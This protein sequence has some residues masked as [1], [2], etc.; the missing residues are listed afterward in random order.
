MDK[1]KKAALKAERKEF[2]RQMSILFKENMNITDRYIESIK[3]ED[4]RAHIKVNLRNVDSPFSIYSNGCILDQ[5]IFDYIDGRTEH[6]RS[7]MPLSIDFLVKKDFSQKTEDD[8][9][10]SYKAHYHIAYEEKRRSIKTNRMISIILMVIGILVL[11]LYATVEILNVI[12]KGEGIILSELISIVA[13][14]FIWEATD[15]IFFE[16]TLKKIDTFA[17][18]QLAIAEINIVREK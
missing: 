16:S 13:W 12:F 17:A 4:Q 1:N 6:I 18:G 15:K 11:M 2:Q 10:I 5:S 9:R 7:S 14:V 3:E 8:L